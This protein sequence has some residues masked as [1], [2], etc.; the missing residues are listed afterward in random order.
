[1]KKCARCLTSAKCGAIIYGIADV[2]RAY[3]GLCSEINLII[4]AD[5]KRAYI[6]RIY[7]QKTLTEKVLRLQ[8]FQ[9]A[10]VWCDAVR[11]AFAG[12]FPSRSAE[13]K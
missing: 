2:K 10:A 12:S 8:A 11:T 1:M 7:S 9:R 4:S 3:I 5:V 13:H 6:G